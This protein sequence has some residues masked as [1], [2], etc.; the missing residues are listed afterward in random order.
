MSG[1]IALLKNSLRSLGLSHNILENEPPAI[2]MLVNLTVL[3]IEGNRSSLYGKI[4]QRGDGYTKTCEKVVTSNGKS[5][6][7]PITGYVTESLVRNRD[8]GAWYQYLEPY[9]HYLIVNRA[10]NKPWKVKL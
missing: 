9:S 8:A 1:D 7:L 4:C 3:R 10:K 2:K 6:S 5:L